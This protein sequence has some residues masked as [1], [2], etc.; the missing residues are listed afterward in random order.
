[1]ITGLDL[2]RRWKDCLKVTFAAV[3]LLSS[4]LCVEIIFGGVM[5]CRAFFS[6][7]FVFTLSAGTLYAQNQRPSELY[8][9][10]SN[11]QGEGLNS[12]NDPNN[13][14]SNDFLNRRT[15]LHGITAAVTWF[16]LESFGLTGDASVNRKTK[17]D[18]EPE[19]TNSTTIDVWY[20]MV[21]PTLTLPG[22]SRFK[23]FGR[24]LAG[25]AHTAFE[26]KQR[27]V[28]GNGTS[29]NLFEVGST[30]FSIGVGGGLDMMVTARFKVR[31]FQVDYSP[32]FLGDRSINVLSEAGIIQPF[33]LDGQRQD[34]VRISF[35]IIF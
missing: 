28:L 10:Y 30:D 19:G 23:P 15:T 22:T 27:Q 5:L 34:N 13:F 20:F 26:S 9:G 21:G 3:H 35:G 24:V 18:D 17:S 31:L 33:Q 1:M 16:P 4:S 11:L 32:I 25:V 8:V 12:Q 2:N 29:T 6:V 14:I 7:L